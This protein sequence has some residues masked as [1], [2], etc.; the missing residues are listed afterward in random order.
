M[1]LR[2]TLV[3]FFVLFEPGSLTQLVLGMVTT[4]FFL[5]I[6]MQ[7]SPYRHDI[8]TYLAVSCN[9]SLA[10]FFLC[11]ITFKIITFTELD[12]VQG[13][14][15]PDLVADYDTPVMALTFGMIVCLLLASGLAAI[16]VVW[17]VD[18]DFRQRR[19]VCHIDGDKEAV[20][21]QVARGHFHLFLSHNW[22]Q[23][24]DEMRVV[25][26]RLHEMLPNAHGEIIK[27][28]AAASA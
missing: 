1:M 22:T 19:R 6:Q 28:E 20:C 11:C 10:L 9:C 17:R 5:L 2:L 27:L 4:L 7:A 26:Q 13:V 3:G 8:D 15:T 18:K 12:K 23:G 24:Q 25:R 21:P 14:M 16:F